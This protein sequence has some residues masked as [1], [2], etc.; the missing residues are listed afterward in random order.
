[1]IEIY[2]GVIYRENFKISPF[3]RV[4]EKLFTFKEKYKYEKKIMQALIKLVMNSF[5]SVQIRREF[6]ES[7]YCKS[8]NWMKTEYYENVL[9]YWKVSMGN[10][11]VKFKEE[12]G[13]DD[14][15]DVKNILTEHLG[16]FILSNSTRVMNNF[17]RKVDGF[18][19][20]IVYYTDTDSLY[21]EK[22]YWDIFDEAGLVGDNLCQG[23]NDYKSGV[24]L[25]GLFLAPE[26]KYSKE[27]NKGNWYY[28]RA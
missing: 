23:K 12:D 11:I 6:N 14:D 17:I 26:I 9:G 4:I 19:S 18:Y 5:N 13:L 8:Q 27:I 15:I 24:V 25:Y 7:F 20:N 16:A 22:K 3:R 2:E 21:I 10:Y 28:R 1:M